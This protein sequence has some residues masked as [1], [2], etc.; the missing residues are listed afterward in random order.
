MEATATGPETLYYKAKNFSRVGIKFLIKPENYIQAMHAS[1]K[2][3]EE[4]QA[5]DRSTN[6]ATSLHKWIN[7]W[8]LGLGLS[9][10]GFTA[11]AE[12]GATA[13]YSTY[14]SAYNTDWTILSILRLQSTLWLCS[15]GPI[16]CLWIQNSYYVYSLYTV[17][18]VYDDTMS[19]ESSIV[20]VQLDYSCKP[21]H[22]ITHVLEFEFD[23]SIVFEFDCLWKVNLIKTRRGEITA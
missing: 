23:N 19:M 12:A 5:N 21:T 11:H 15:K 10:A 2:W 4:S 17:A 20:L 16:L 14:M 18:I 13:M 22:Y 8:S 9:S 6:L 7:A 1:S 3:S